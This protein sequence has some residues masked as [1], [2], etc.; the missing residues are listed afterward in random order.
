MLCGYGYRLAE[1]ILAS[2]PNRV[3]GVHD[4]DLRIRNADGGPRYPGLR[5]VRDAICAGESEI[6]ST[7]YLVTP[8]VDAGPPLVVS[9][10]Y[11]VSL[12]TDINSSGDGIGTYVAVHREQMIRQCWGPLLR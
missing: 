12:P 11:P 6:R 10:S 7:V 9:A 4:A 8:E 1:P 5:A 3:I 2:W